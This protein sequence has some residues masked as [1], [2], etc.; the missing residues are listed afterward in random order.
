[1]V[2]QGCRLKKTSNGFRTSDGEREK[3]EL[4]TA[5]DNGQPQ[6]LRAQIDRADQLQMTAS[7]AAIKRDRFVNSE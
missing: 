6:E 4:R 7:M 5:D 1:M 3:T 2:G